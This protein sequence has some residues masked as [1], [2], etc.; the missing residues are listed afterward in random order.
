MALKALYASATGTTQQNDDEECSCSGLRDVTNEMML[1]KNLSESNWSSALDALY[2]KPHSASIWIINRHGRT[3]PLHAAILYG[4]PSHVTIEILKAFPNAAREKDLQGRLPIHIAAS[5]SAITMT[6]DGEHV[7]NELVREFPESL[8]VEDE[9]G[10]T[11]M[12]L[13]EILQVQKNKDEKRSLECVDDN[14]KLVEIQQNE[15]EQQQQQESTRGC[16]NQSQHEK[17]NIDYNSMYN[18]L[19]V[20]QSDTSL[21]KID[22]EVD[23]KQQQ[24]KHEHKQNQQ[25]EDNY[26]AMYD[27]LSKGQSDISRLKTS[28]GRQDTKRN[29][30][31]KP[32]TVKDDEAG[33]S[34]VS[35]SLTKMEDETDQS[36]MSIPLAQIT[37]MPKVSIEEDS[38]VC[39]P[40]DGS[41]C[42]D[43]DEITSGLPN[44]NGEAEKGDD[45]DITIYTEYAMD[46]VEEKVQ[47]NKKRS[48]S[49]PDMLKMKS[50]RRKKNQ[51]VDSVDNASSPKSKVDKSKNTPQQCDC[52]MCNTAATI[53]KDMEEMRKE[54]LEF[55]FIMPTLLMDYLVGSHWDNVMSR[56]R[57]APSEAKAWVRKE[58]G[59]EVVLE[60]LPLHAALLFA[61]PS[62][63]IIALIEAYPSGA[64]EIDGNR[65]FPIHIAASCLS[66]IGRGDIVV[67]HLL[68][69]FHSGKYAVDAKGRTPGDIVSIM[70]TCNEHKTNKHGSGIQASTSRF[71]EDAA[72]AR[73][74]EMAMT[75]LNMP[76][77][78][79]Y[80][81]LRQASAK[82]IETLDDLVMAEDKVLDNVFIQKELIAELRRLLSSF[83]EGKM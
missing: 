34:I 63:V 37:V 13:V 3:L 9:S 82:G 40:K 8:W 12:E 28:V 72:F 42:C 50:K 36:V 33:Q 35:Q 5:I 62:D 58:V 76:L 29:G 45:D 60:V 25:E 53:T 68:K 61:A 19:S 32:S 46:A 51:L 11:A 27:L 73:L 64:G 22:K 17:E 43:H 14:E 48:Q 69:T 38:C 77:E 54:L 31:S 7:I 80:S 26:K 23:D 65:S 20:G 49:S 66:R 79:H 10:R 15:P 30:V 74:M 1:H 59:G 18:L 39:S 70:S 44:S 83:I 75:N 67:D 71:E 56:I 6:V 81:F 24:Q 2:E 52:Y 4:A 16:K 21:L 47:M 78:Y 41:S 55:D 57:D